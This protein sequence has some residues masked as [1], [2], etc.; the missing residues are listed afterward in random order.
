M[1]GGLFLLSMACQSQWRQFL[2]FV[3]NACLKKPFKVKLEGIVASLCSYCN[4][5]STINTHALLRL[6]LR[7]PVH[8]LDK[9]GQRL[10]VGGVR[11]RLGP[12]WGA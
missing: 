5:Y 3:A 11:H 7:L 2:Y 6:D 1:I 12:E 9:L 10:L 4:T 8:A